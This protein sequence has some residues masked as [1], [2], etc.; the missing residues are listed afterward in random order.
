MV[1]TKAHNRMIAG[2]S[3]NVVDFGAV[4]D[5]VTDDR[6]AFV[7]AFATGK[8]VYVPQSSSSYYISTPIEMP[9]NTRIYG[10]MEVHDTSTI[11]T[12]IYAPAGFL[13]NTSGSRVFVDIK[14]LEIIGNDTAGTKAIDGPF[15]GK[16]EGCRF[17]N[18]DI[19]IYNSSA[20]LLSF[21]RNHFRD[22]NVGLSLDDP[23]LT[24][25]ENNWFGSSCK[26]PIDTNTIGTLEGKPL[27]II[28]NNFNLGTNSQTSVIRIGQLNFV[29]NYVE[30]FSAVSAGVPFMD[31]IAERFS[32]PTLNITDNQLNGQSN[33]DTFVRIYS[34]NV[35][36][37]TVEGQITRNWLRGYNDYPIIFND[38][39]G[40]NDRV[41]GIK[42]FDNQVVSTPYVEFSAS[43]LDTD[44]SNGANLTYSGTLDVSSSSFVTV[45]FTIDADFNRTV[46]LGQFKIEHNG[47]YKI[48]VVF[49]AVYASECRGFEFKLVN[50]G[51]TI[52]SKVNTLPAVVSGGSN[53]A[54]ISMSKILYLDSGDDIYFQARNGDEITEA[55]MCIERIG[56][57]KNFVSY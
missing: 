34:D 13:V 38:P 21:I 15:G 43:Y 16:I 10:E 4:G 41:A 25:I 45:P 5:G 51:S 37:T 57:T 9:L 50:S 42:I 7:S 30:A 48:E 17:K 32:Y 12:D 22:A 8:P 24:N 54:T 11:S 6:G 56:D 36:G 52:D 49:Q 46:S 19:L 27:N 1:L 35:S 14:N 28:R 44:T 29:E 23:N 40:S 20:Y 47:L 3:V 2:S 53:Y 55:T 26:K 33:I 31:I 39:L 18:Y